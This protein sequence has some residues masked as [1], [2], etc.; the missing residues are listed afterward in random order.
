MGFPGGSAVSSLVATP[1][2]KTWVP[3]I[4]AVPHHASLVCPVSL[5]PSPRSLG[6]AWGQ[7]AGQAQVRSS[8]TELQFL[9]GGVPAAVPGAG[10]QQWN[11]MVITRVS[12]RWPTA[13]TGWSTSCKLCDH[14]AGLCSAQHILR[15]AGHH[16]A[17]G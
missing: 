17:K 9:L 2:Y 13:R 7:V 11:E 5:S 12:S 3:R 10:T 1:L 4:S 6:L 8:R 14:C 16:K 15:K